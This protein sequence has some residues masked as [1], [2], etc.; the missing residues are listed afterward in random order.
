MTFTTTIL[1]LHMYEYYSSNSSTS[2]HTVLTSVNH[3]PSAVSL[4][5][6]CA[7][8]VTSATEYRRQFTHTDGFDMCVC[9]VVCALSRKFSPFSVSERYYI[10]QY[11]R[12]QYVFVLSLPTALLLFCAFAVA[13][14][15]ARNTCYRY[16][17]LHFAHVT[18]QFRHDTTELCNFDAVLL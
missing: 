9:G 14:L 5:R 2:K 3:F 17:S 16:F 18:V 1:G 8:R 11:R 6:A 15:S 13:N 7:S 4:T 12:K 10:V